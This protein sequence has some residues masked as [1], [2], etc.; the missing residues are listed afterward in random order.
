VAQSRFEEGDIEEGVL[1]LS[2]IGLGVQACHQLQD[3]NRWTD[4]AWLAKLTLSE[5]DCHKVL[6]EWANHLRET[7]KMKAVHLLVTLGLFFE[8]FE[9][10]YSMGYIGTAVLYAEACQQRGISFEPEVLQKVFVAYGDFLKQ[11]GL[12]E[13]A[14]HYWEK[15]KQN[16]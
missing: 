16:H 2:V 7:D 11:L 8:G 14:Q 12:L 5:E 1:L 13:L 10:L 9:L 15:G 3:M 4:A 6:R